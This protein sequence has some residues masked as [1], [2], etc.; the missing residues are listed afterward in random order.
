M[1]TESS[2]VRVNDK[3]RFTDEGEPKMNDDAQPVELDGGS[4]TQ[5][6]D[7]TAQLT[8]ARAR[9]DELARAYQASEQ[10]KVDVRR[11]LERERDRLIEVDRGEVAVALLEAID[12]LELCLSSVKD[13]ALVSGVKLIRDGLL[14]RAEGLGVERLELLHK[15][16]D[17]QLAEATDTELTTDLSADGTVSLVVKACYQLKG[18]VVRA[19]QVRVARY[20]APAH[21]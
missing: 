3:R 7:L 1:A 16:F 12:Q 18:R 11:R 8:A 5:I 17:P 10:E 15:P 9:V 21:A 19:G 20:V 14:K 2:S 13:A 6:A 4:Q